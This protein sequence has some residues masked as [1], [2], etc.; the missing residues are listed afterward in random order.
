MTDSKPLDAALW[1]DGIAVGD[2]FYRHVN[3]RW[4]AAQ[5]GAAGVP[6]CGAPTSSSTS[7]TRS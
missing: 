5:P 3:A 7:A 6:A 1:D 2:D 4:L